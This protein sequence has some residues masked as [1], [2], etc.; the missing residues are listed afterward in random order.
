LSK[1]PYE[2]LRDTYKVIN[3][4]IKD[5]LRQPNVPEI[6]KL[7][8][9]LGY[10]WDTVLSYTS[11]VS[12][13]SGDVG[14]RSILDYY[15]ETINLRFTYDLHIAASLCLPEMVA[16]TIQNML[17]YLVS[18]VMID[19]D[20]NMSKQG[21]DSKFSALLRMVTYGD[22]EKLFKFFE[23]LGRRDVARILK[24]FY[25]ELVEIVRGNLEILRLQEVDE[26]AVVSA[27]CRESPRVAET[28]AEL[29]TEY[30][31][32]LRTIIDLWVDEITGRYPSTGIF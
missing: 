31:D 15:M 4:I 27:S 30:T 17:I 8:D 14:Y 5:T 24:D 1:R 23:G 28:I 19:L 26:G 12:E 2:N 21:L 16:Q 20:E 13:I 10:N 25:D 32:I 22:R 3:D 18:S 9:A 11:L 29:I 7:D 6:V